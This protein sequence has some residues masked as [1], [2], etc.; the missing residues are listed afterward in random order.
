MSQSIKFNNNLIVAVAEIPKLNQKFCEFVDEHFEE[1]ME[2]SKIT[3]K[4][5]HLRSV[6]YYRKFMDEVPKR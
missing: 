6:K 2:N 4:E 5:A 3:E 1:S